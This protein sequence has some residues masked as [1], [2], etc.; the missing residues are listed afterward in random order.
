[1][2][3]QPQQP[4]DRAGFAVL[5]TDKHTVYS[6]IDQ[7]RDGGAR[8]GSGPFFNRSAKVTLTDAAK[9]IIEQAKK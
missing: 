3:T 4:T 6:T 7:H 1:M 9:K 8:T 2:K 5:K